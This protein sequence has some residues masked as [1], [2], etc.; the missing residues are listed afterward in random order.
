VSRPIVILAVVVAM[1]GL[2]WLLVRKQGLLVPG[3][4][5]QTKVHGKAPAELSGGKPPHFEALQPWLSED[6]NAKPIPENMRG[7]TDDP[8]VVEL[9]ATYRK[10]E[11]GKIVT[12]GNGLQQLWEGRRL[13]FEAKRIGS[14]SMSAD[15]TIALDAVTGIETPIEDAEISGSGDDIRLISSPREIWV[16][17]PTGNKTRVSPLGVDAFVPVLAPSGKTIAFTGRLL[18]GKGFPSNQRLYVGVPATGQYRIFAGDEHFH[19]YKVWP[20]DWVKNG[21]VLRVLQD[22]GETG[23]HMKLKQVRLE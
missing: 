12:A 19:D 13:V 5:P 2:L 11:I 8:A 18:D 15:G 7:A 21:T 3:Q 4:D 1:A 6:S 10:T 9:V 22:H 14:R 16:V 20:V 17:A 23:G